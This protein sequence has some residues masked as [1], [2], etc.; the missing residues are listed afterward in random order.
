MKVEKAIIIS[1]AIASVDCVS[2]KVIRDTT[3]VPTDATN[4]AA[5]DLKR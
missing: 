2:W 1:R 4:D 5:N 3:R